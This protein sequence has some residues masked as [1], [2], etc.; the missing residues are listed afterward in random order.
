MKNVTTNILHQKNQSKINVSKI[1]AFVLLFIVCFIWILPLLYMLGTSFK[2]EIDLITNPTGLLPTKGHWTLEHYTGFIIR[3]GQL[4]NLPKWM[5]NSIF[6]AVMSVVLTIIVDAFAAYA[7]VFLNLRGK[8][9]L[10]K[11][12]LM[13][14]TIPGVIGTTTS[15]AMFAT[16]GKSLDLLTQQWYVF[17]WLIFP[18][19]SGVF[20]MYLMKNFLDSIPKDIVESARSDGAKDFRIFISIIMPLAKSTILLIAL[21]VFTGSWNNLLWPQLILGATGNITGWS[22][23]TVALTGYAAGDSLT[24]NGIAMATSVFSLIPIVIVFIFTQNK[25]I[26]GM[27]TTGIKQ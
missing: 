2:D 14:M 10:F 11:L 25:M 27:A 4:D 1:V 17:F 6:V 21:F 7:F 13:S 24:R 9:T 5:M 20:N 8:E 26:E 3:E 23:V 16:I 12:L 18:G 15:F 19:L 22:T